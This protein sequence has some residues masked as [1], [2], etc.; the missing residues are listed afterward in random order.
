MTDTGS[1]KT[2]ISPAAVLAVVEALYAYADEPAQWADISAAV[3]ALPLPLDPSKDPEAATIVSHAAR[4][5]AMIERLNAGRTP[6]LT[7]EGAWDAVLLSSERRVRG[8]IGEVAQRLAPFLTKSIAAGEPLNFNLS[9]AQIFGEAM[10]ASAAA[11]ET[12]LSPFTLEST[13]EGTRCFGVVLSREA[14]PHALSAAFGLNDVWAEPL[15]ALVLLSA[16]EVNAVGKLVPRRFGLTAAESRLAAKLLQGL[17]V[18]DAAQELGVTTNTARSYLKNIF[19]KTGAKR[20]A[21]LLHLLTNATEFP[22]QLPNGHPM[23][24]PGSPPRR[25][26][27]LQDGRK[28]YYREYGVPTGRPVVYFHFGLAASLMTPEAANAA[29]K[30]RVRVIAFDRPGYG[31][32]DPHS[33]YTFESIAGDV[34]ELCHQLKLRSITLFGDGYGGGFAVAAALR[35]GAEIQRLALRGPNLGRT[36]AATDGRLL[37]SLFRQPW[38]IPGAAEMLRRGLRISVIRSLL[39]NY[40]EKSRSDAARIADPHF[41][42]YLNSTIFD[43]LERSSVGLSSELIMFASGAKVD[44]ASLSCQIGVWHGDENPAVPVKESI[45]AFANHKYAQLHILRGGGLY[46]KQPVFEE[47]FS[48]LAETTDPSADT[49]ALP[50]QSGQPNQIA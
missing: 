17:T 21:D 31:Q 48:W 44:P 10:Q 9:A 45:A 19:S 13:D 20:Q 3:E 23:A 36:A 27:T 2:G 8:S 12:A 46:L 33:D 30:A 29:L 37:G 5:A 35:M 7:P 43:A 32:S 15:F 42:A 50:S 25:F 28:L 26:V 11:T 49:R 34:Q 1:N 22:A 18:T 4:A 6:K 40:A 16:R 41:A 14:F 39:S 24:F 47:I 38:I